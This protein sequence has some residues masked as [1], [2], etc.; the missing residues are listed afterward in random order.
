[1]QTVAKPDPSQGGQP[2]SEAVF[3]PAS[4]LG[5]R[6]SVIVPARNEQDSI[7]DCLRSLLEQAEPGWEL[8]RQWELI[9][10]DD[11]STDATHAI[12]QN[13]LQSTE[14]TR[15]LEAPAL[16]AGWMGKAHACAT[17]VAEAKGEWLLFTDADT[18]HAPGRLSIAVTE[19]ERHQVAMLSYSPRQLVDGVVA[20]GLMALIFSELESVYP[21]AKVNH[22]SSPIVAANGQFL[23][24][25]RDAYEAVGGHE[26]VRQTVLEDLMLAKQ[27]KQ[28][29]LGLRF[30]YAPEAVSARMYRSLGAMEQGW[31]KNL[32]QLFPKT[33]VL[34][35]WRLL[36]LF[37]LLGLPVAAWLLVTFHVTPWYWGAVLVLWLRTILRFWQRIGRSH[38]SSSTCALAPVA[39][40]LYA[41]LLLKSWWNY[42]V[43]DRIEWKG[44]VYSGSGN[45]QRNR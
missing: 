42:R 7:A 31:S 8:G 38:F 43:K 34:A 22:P 37:L 19:A 18:I 21:V 25:R 15:L 26:A 1:M 41:F 32:A 17:G 24:V 39:L 30:R 36:D 23:L 16:P 12:A 6:L 33:A 13:L 20:R 27:I 44:R 2:L 3:T 9:V 29:K 35:L 10:V 40:P 11:H 28:R 4:L 45:A 14:G 5:L